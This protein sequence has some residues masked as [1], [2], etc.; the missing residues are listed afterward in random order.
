LVTLSTRPC[1]FRHKRGKSSVLLLFIAF[2]LASEVRT[3]NAYLTSPRADVV[4]SITFILGLNK[5]HTHTLTSPVPTQRKP[6]SFLF[7]ASH[8]ADHTNC[9]HFTSSQHTVMSN[10]SGGTPGMGSNPSGGTPGMGNNPSGGTP[11]MGN[12]PSGGTPGMGNNPSGG[13]W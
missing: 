13:Y 11:G 7:P 2:V 5:A 1:T 4:Y 8:C 6:L 9:T 3:I 10:A 12:N